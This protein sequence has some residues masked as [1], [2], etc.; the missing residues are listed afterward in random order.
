MIISDWTGTIHPLRK[1]YSFYASKS[2]RI[3]CLHLC[4]F[5]FHTNL[6]PVLELTWKGEQI[7]DL[8]QSE[9]FP[10]MPLLLRLVIRTQKMQTLIDLR[11]FH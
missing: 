4:P 3:L 10:S 5:P 1:Q 2:N 8:S 7:Y 6:R 11:R 9:L